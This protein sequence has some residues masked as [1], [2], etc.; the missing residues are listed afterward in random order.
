MPTLPSGL[1][2]AAAAL[3]LLYLGLAMNVV[4]LRWA[5]R[6]SLGDGGHKDLNQA[7]RAHANFI[8]YVPFVLVL[9]G[10]AALRGA[11]GG[12]VEGA[13]WAL[14]LARGLH[15]FG[16]TRSAKANPGRFVGAALSFA[17]LAFAGGLAAWPTLG[18]LL[19]AG[20]G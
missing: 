11:P 8:E 18:G 7:I 16:L 15:A 14:V 9:L 19:A 4:R 2:S 20:S 5:R 13:A 3:A 10:F 17:L 1:A 6:V 12:W